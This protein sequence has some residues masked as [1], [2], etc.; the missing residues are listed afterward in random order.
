[1]RLIEIDEYE[2]ETMQLAKPIHDQYHRVL[3][4]QGA[5]I[6]DKYLTTL[7]ELGIR[8]L[9][10]EDAISH[11]IT[12][13]EMFD[14]PTW[15]DAVKIVHQTFNQVKKEEKLNLIALQ[16]LAGQLI[17]EVQRRKIL[18]LIPSTTMAKDLLLYTHSVNVAIL[19]LEIGRQMGYNNIQ[20]RDLILGALL[21]DIGK[22]LIEEVKEHPKAGFQ[23]LRHIHELN[24]MC[25]H[26]SYQH[27]ERWNGKGYPREIRGMQIIPYAQIVSI[28]NFY[29]KAISRGNKPHLVMET[30]MA[31]S[32]TVFAP[33]IISAFIRSVPPYPPGTTVHL[34]SGEEVVVT[35]I[36]NLMQRPIVRKGNMQEISLEDEPTILIDG[37]K[38]CDKETLLRLL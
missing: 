10:V 35:G 38:E 23:F 27:H 18:A 13:D 29:E 7:K 20:L 28:A 11:D 3:L 24:L 15:M 5:T 30:I 9:F 36:R 1:M 26:V 31:L 34:M 32:D 17:I 12:M 2:R 25:A 33:E 22:V 4:N 8:Y 37:G 6:H 19:S 21:H 14:M 16:E